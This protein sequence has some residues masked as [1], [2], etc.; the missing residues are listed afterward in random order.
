MS[1]HFWRV[2]GEK[3]P[4]RAEVPM[5][6]TSVPRSDMIRYKEQLRTSGPS[7]RSSVPA[8]ASKPISR[9][10]TVGREDFSPNYPYPDQYYVYTPYISLK[11]TPVPVGQP[12]ARA[13]MNGHPNYPS[14]SYNMIPGITTRDSDVALNQPY[15]YHHYYG[16][17][18]DQSWE[19]NMPLHQQ[20]LQDLARARRMRHL[21]R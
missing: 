18:Y 16:P 9:R 7:S 19:Y 21:R 12:G 6:A 11:S 17:T 15:W 8:A 20:Y 3:D 5:G 2:V 1:T 4:P 14:L 13:H 10:R